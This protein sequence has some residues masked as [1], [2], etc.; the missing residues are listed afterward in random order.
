MGI[1]IKNKL[2]GFVTGGVVGSSMILL[3]GWLT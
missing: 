2:Y 1:N 3:V